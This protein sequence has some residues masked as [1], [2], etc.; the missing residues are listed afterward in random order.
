MLS[1]LTG[2]ISAYVSSTDSI[3]LIAVFE[4]SVVSSSNLGKSLYKIFIISLLN[5]TFGLK[6]SRKLTFYFNKN[7][8]KCQ[9]VPFSTFL[10][11][12]LILYLYYVGENLNANRL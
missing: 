12:Y 8:N 7:F 4:S 10:P 5:K 11:F 2:T 3:T 6:V 1:N 9:V